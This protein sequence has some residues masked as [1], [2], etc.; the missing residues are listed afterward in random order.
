MSGGLRAYRTEIR[1]TVVV[2]VLAVL[3]VV[4]L[5]PRE[6]EQPPAPG[7][8]AAPRPAPDRTVDPA[9]RAAAGLQAC[10]PAE[11]APPPELAGATGSC[12]ADGTR[13]DLGAVVGDGPALIN[14]WATW[15]AP[16]RTELPALQRYAE[17]PGSVPVVGVQVLS[18]AASGLDLLTELGVRFPTVHDEDNR[19][20]AALGVPAVLPASYVVTERGELRR[21]DPPVV[22]ESAD[23][24]SDAV[25]RTLEGSR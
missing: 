1:W 8:T 7:S 4:A 9:Q 12:L 11:G 20:R 16:C 18:D 24:V 22:F 19:L 14:V 2:V 10:A 13:A 25:R 3:G 6:T 21:I 15:C 23:E 5:W 17:R